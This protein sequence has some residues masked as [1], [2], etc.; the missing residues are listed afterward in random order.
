MGR[1]QIQWK[2][3]LQD[4]QK[5]TDNQS[6]EELPHH[7]MDTDGYIVGSYRSTVTHLYIYIYNISI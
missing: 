3:S 6:K 1:M 2:T 4:I 5:R 7:L